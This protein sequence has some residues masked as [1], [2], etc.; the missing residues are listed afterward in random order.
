M[1]KA[2]QGLESKKSEVVIKLAINNSEFADKLILIFKCANTSAK[3]R[4]KCLNSSQDLTKTIISLA[5]A[6]QGSQMP[7]SSIFSNLSYVNC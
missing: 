5:T 7:A 2:T 4:E 3:T 1:L 6:S